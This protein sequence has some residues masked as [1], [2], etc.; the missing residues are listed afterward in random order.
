MSPPSMKL[1]VAMF[2]SLFAGLVMALPNLP[3]G[4]VLRDVTQPMIASVVHIQDN[5]VVERYVKLLPLFLRL[6]KSRTL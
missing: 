1:I 2:I 4:F 5:G 3:Y 6:F